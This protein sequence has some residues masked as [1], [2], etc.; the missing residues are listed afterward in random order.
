V[1]TGPR[2]WQQACAWYIWRDLRV[3]SL[4]AP[5]DGYHDTLTVESLLQDQK[6]ARR[7]SRYRSPRTSRTVRGPGF[8]IFPSRAGEGYGPSFLAEMLPWPVGS[9]AEF[10][11]AVA[12]GQVTESELHTVDP[13]EIMRV[14]PAPAGRIAAETAE[15][16]AET[17]VGWVP[18]GIVH[19]E[20]YYCREVL[21]RRV[22]E[23]MRKRRL[24]LRGSHKDERWRASKPIPYPYCLE[25]GFN[26]VAG[27]SREDGGKPRF[28]GR[29]YH[30]DVS[31]FH[32]NNRQIAQADYDRLRTE[33]C[34]RPSH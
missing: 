33:I 22:E 21:M 2:S 14:F 11:R 24:E 1:R 34:E 19:N 13:A 3:V 30:C 7:P 4:V 27:P 17:P 12:N 15:W 23:E 26:W 31:A 16:S 32:L 8:V 18:L 29:K 10:E 25:L 6:N 5:K 20:N 28:P 9:I